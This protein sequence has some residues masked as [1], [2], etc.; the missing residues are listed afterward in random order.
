MTTWQRLVVDCPF[1]SS[2]LKPIALGVLLDAKEQLTDISTSVIHTGTVIKHFGYSIG[3]RIRV[4][5]DTEPIVFLSIPSLTVAEKAAKD[6]QTLTSSFR[7]LLQFLYGSGF[8]IDSD[9]NVGV[10]ALQRPQSDLV[11]AL[12]VPETGFLMIGNGVHH[13]IYNFHL[14]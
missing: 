10:P 3:K 6:K 14:D 2:K 7:T 1:I 5:N 8:S 12:R 9:R 4:V 13:A 11:N